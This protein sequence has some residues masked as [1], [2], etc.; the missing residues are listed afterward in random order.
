MYQWGDGFFGAR[1]AS[2]SGDDRK[3]KPVLTLR[4]KVRF[5]FRVPAPAPDRDSHL[6]SFLMDRVIAAGRMQDIMKVQVTESRV[7]ALS[8]SGRVY[9]ISAEACRQTLAPPGAPT[10]SRAARWGAGWVWGDE[11][12]VQHAEIVP[13]Q[14]LAWGERYA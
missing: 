9:I 11:G 1:S 3:K 14:K 7:F 6:V 10:P 4:G 12:G 13:A 2:V 8:A 5:F